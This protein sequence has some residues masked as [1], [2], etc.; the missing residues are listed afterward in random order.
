MTESHS[1]QPPRELADGEHDESE[2][3][4][5]EEIAQDERRR[6]KANRACRATL[7]ALLC[8]EAFVMLLVP[9]AIAQ[10]STGLNATKT[11]LLIGLAV[12]LVAVGTKL[13]APWGIAAG[14]VMQ[15]VV[16]GTGVLE[17]T[18]FLV[19]AVFIGIWIYTLNLRHQLVGT[20]GGV[21]MLYS[22]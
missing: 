11:I 15:I 8:L 9:R 12:V 20:P 21:Q 17:P 22:P 5:D 4:T 7:A 18:L 3:M 2:Y 14:S 10:T 13:R 16:L 19:G 6:M 1:D